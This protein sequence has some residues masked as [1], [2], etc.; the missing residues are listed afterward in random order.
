M[1]AI[2]KNFITGPLQVNT[3]VIPCETGSAAVID[4]GGATPELI[5][6]LKNLSIEHIEIMLTHGHFDHIGG[7]A[8]LVETFPDYSLWIHQEDAYRLKTKVRYSS[9]GLALLAQQYLGKD[10]QE[11]MP[12]A[13]NFLNE[14]DTVNGLSVLHTPGHTKGSVCFFNESEKV[15]YSGDTLFLQSFGR[16]DLEG[17]DEN[18]MRTTLKRLFT[19]LPPETVVHP[20]HGGSTTIGYETKIQWDYWFS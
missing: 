4:P 12:E 7:I 18:Q 1:K 17:G 8:N 16:T 15:L 5:A 10:W 9:D 13:T 14:G 20:G 11:R 2:G 6:H 3:W 19:T